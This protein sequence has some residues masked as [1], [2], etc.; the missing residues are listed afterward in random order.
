VAWSHWLPSQF[1]DGPVTL[2]GLVVDADGNAYAVGG[3]TGCLAVGDKVVQSVVN[4]GTSVES[5]DG[6]GSPSPDAFF[7]KL[8]RGGNVIWLKSIGGVA[9]QRPTSLLEDAAGNLVMLITFRGRFDID[10]QTFLS[11]EGSTGSNGVL[12]TFDPDGTLLAAQQ[13][14]EGYGVYGTCMDSQGNFILASSASAQG[15]WVAKRDPNWQL[16]WLET[17][18]D[19]IGPRPRSIAVDL[20]DNIVIAAEAYGNPRLYGQPIVDQGAVLIKLSPDGAPIFANLYGSSQLDSANDVAI[21]SDNSIAITGAFYESIDFGAGVLTALEPGATRSDVF[22]AKLDAN[23]GHLMSLHA[24]G[25]D[26]DSGYGMAALP[27][28][29]LVTAGFFTTAID[30]GSGPIANRGGPYVAWLPAGQGR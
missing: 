1:D 3:F 16:V 15:G 21:L 24:G 29:E 25:I 10:G 8:D 4:P 6:R 13:I 12:A 11:S 9:D 14:T 17:F 27:G 18:D 5:L 28:D 20:E 2:G 23:G 22:V 26:T 30:F 19:V 7:L